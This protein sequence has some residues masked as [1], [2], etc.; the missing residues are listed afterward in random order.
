KIGP[1]KAA[2]LAE[3]G[4][5]TVGDLVWHLPR[6]YEDRRETTPVRA[7]AAGAT[8]Q[9][10]GRLD[11]VRLR[12]AGR[13]AIV[14]ATLRDETGTL[15]VTWFGQPW[16]VEKLAAVGEVVLH[17]RVQ[18][19]GSRLVLAH[20][21]WRPAGEAT[22]AVAPVYP[23]CGGLP[24]A[25]LRVWIAAALPRLDLERWAPEPLPPVLL[26]RHGLPDLAAAL[27]FL[28]SPPASADVAALAAAETPA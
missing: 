28:H 24:G 27:R 23:D 15:P 3:A 16:L 6:T 11:R 7:A 5:A 26:R 4:I 13:R 10:R 14:E 18:R 9:V 25:A 21:E 19:A 8:V 1:K 2:M 17:G 12:R 22:A 20:P